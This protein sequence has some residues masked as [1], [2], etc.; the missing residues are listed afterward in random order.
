MQSNTITIK[1]FSSSVIKKN[2]ELTIR[3]SKRIN[4]EQ[5]YLQTK[6]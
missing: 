2:R 6:I 3:K 1:E 5:D 4:H